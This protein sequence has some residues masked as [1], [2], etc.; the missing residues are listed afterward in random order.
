MKKYF[1]TRIAELLP[2]IGVDMASYLGRHIFSAVFGRVGGY[3]AKT[4]EFLTALSPEHRNVH[5]GVLCDGFV[6]R[7]SWRG[8]SLTYDAPF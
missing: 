7:H 2:R 1:G 5:A 4:A 6:V 3:N 8:R